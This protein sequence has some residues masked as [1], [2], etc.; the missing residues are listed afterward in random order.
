[1]KFKI[2]LSKAAADPLH[3]ARIIITISLLSAAVLLL[4][5]LAAGMYSMEKA[6]L[7]QYDGQRDLWTE[8]STLVL[9]ASQPQVIAARIRSQEGIDR[10]GGIQEER[11]WQGDLTGLLALL[12]LV[13]LVGPSLLVWGIRARARWYHAPPPRRGTV[14]IAAALTIGG[15][16]VLSQAAT[17]I[18]AIQSQKRFTLMMEDIRS[19]AEW[20]ALS[21]EA[22]LMARKAQVLYFLPPKDGG[23]GMSWLASDG[24]GKPAITLSDIRPAGIPSS[25][26]TEPFYPQQPK[27][28]VV[29]VYRSD[30]L[31]IRGTGNAPGLIDDSRKL[32]NAK[33]HITVTPDKITT[34]YV[35]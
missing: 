32:D 33:V 14:R 19:S 15:F 5:L 21:S 23:C 6:I 4:A 28:Y 12:T 25:K 18:A 16:V 8:F 13:F 17:I 11:Q 2:D 7:Q 31:S 26:I 30:S 1:M 27:S 35:R 24:S 34:L 29:E 20:E 10:F 22:V 3:P 9:T